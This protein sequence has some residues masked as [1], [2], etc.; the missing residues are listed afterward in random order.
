M[1]H[2]STLDIYFNR[3]R[4]E[5]WLLFKINPENELATLTSPALI[6][7]GNLGRH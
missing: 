5:L 1:V 7:C 4:G 6:L 3:E 2:E